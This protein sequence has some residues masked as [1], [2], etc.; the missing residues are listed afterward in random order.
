MALAT[1]ILTFTICL[2]GK[3]LSVNKLMLSLGNQKSK[4]NCL[5]G[6]DS[7]KTTSFQLSKERKLE[8]SLAAALVG[9]VLGTVFQRP[10]EQY[11]L[12]SLII[13]EE[14]EAQ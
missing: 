1:E 5:L 4:S 14:A 11:S 3:R 13:E 12:F 7:S 8:P 10:S 9:L 2:Y 6:V